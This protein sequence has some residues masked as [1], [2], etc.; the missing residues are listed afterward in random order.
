MNGGA[1][2]TGGG[3]GLGKEIAL[4]LAAR[5]YAVHVT[6]IDAT[7]AAQTA[8]EIGGLAWGSAV[9]VRCMDACR[10]AANQ[11]VERAG[12]LELWVNNAGILETGPI[13]QHDMDLW[14]RVIE[15][16]LTGTLHGLSAAL[17]VMRPND[18]GHIVNIASLAGL[19]A[20]PG[21]AVYA[22]TKHGVLGLSLS[23]LADLRVAGFTGIEISCICPDGIWT[24]MI[25]DRLQEP[26]AAMSFSGTLLQPGQVADLVEQVLDRPRPVTSKPVWRGVLARASATAPR[27]AL[28]ALPVIRALGRMQQRRLVRKGAPE[29]K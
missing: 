11:T 10:A 5:G 1:L 24:P 2:V 12:S 9:D 27:L 19:V 26:E 16:N 22:A 21:E 25:Y 17:E 18:G 15:I 23:T 13:W 8:A 4:R 6:D 29:R 7:L 14:H 20:V 28:R 3:Q